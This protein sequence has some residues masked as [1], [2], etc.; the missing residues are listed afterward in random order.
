[1]QQQQQGASPPPFLLAGVPWRL[2]C[3]GKSGSLMLAAT[4][5]P[6]LAVLR[7]LLASTA[8]PPVPRPLPPLAALHHLAPTLPPASARLDFLEDVKGRLLTAMKSLVNARQS[9]RA[10]V[11]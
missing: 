11:E 7:E 1:M 5:A 3:S 2:T 6:S 4:A 9:L 10:L 8:T